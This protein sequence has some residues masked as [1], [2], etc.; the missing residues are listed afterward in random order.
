MINFEELKKYGDKFYPAI[1]LDNLIRFRNR[2][3]Y[4][5]IM[6]T[7][8]VVFLLLMFFTLKI[9]F[10]AKINLT[11][12]SDFLTIYKY[13]FRGM[14][15]IFGILWLNS[16]LVEFFYLYHYF[17]NLKVDYEVALLAYAADSKDVTGSFLHSRIGKKVTG[18]LNISQDEIKHFIKDKDRELINENQIIFKTNPFEKI[19]DDKVINLVDYVKAIYVEDFDFLKFLEKNNLTDEDLYGAC[20]LVQQ[21]GWQNRNKERFWS[22][23]N[24]SRIPS[25]GQNWYSPKISFLEKYAH[26]IYEN[27][28]YQSLGKDWVFFRD[29][30]EKLEQFLLDQKFSNLLLIGKNLETSMEVISAYAKMIASGFAL[31]KFENKR[32]YVLNIDV[33]LLKQK[34]GDSFEKLFNGM[35]DEAIKNGNIILVV[36]DLP[37]LIE[38]S[39]GS[40]FDFV[41]EFSRILNHN[42]IIFI[43]TTTQ[44]DYHSVLETNVDLLNYFDKYFTSTDD[45]YFLRR[46][47]FQEADR[48]EESD[49]V[50]ISYLDIKKIV[51]NLKSE[52]N[53]I[54]KAK[55][56]LYEI[57]EK[58]KYELEK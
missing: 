7:G 42:E 33:L 18:R 43:A 9:E 12:V 40:D 45:D 24:L 50:R 11:A 15:L 28:I 30:A 2:K 6:A 46:A 38:K 37:K 39:D 22:R 19:D 27:K 48:I 5:I 4:K 29:E 26:L 55:R 10:W 3:I 54:K 34:E 57:A 47:M 52:E 25:I 53:P 23:E 58:Q 17:L 41:R 14:A 32:I 36:N 35:I 1:L 16:Y 56:E 13:P 51:N 31:S 8:F 20:E 49:N 21:I 44:D